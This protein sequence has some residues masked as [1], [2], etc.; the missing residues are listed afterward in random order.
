M[1][2]MRESLAK[3]MGN[4]NTIPTASCATTARKIL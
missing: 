2:L 3:A 4:V 1:S